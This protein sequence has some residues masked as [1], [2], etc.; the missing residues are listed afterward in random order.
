ML[1][2][3]PQVLPMTLSSMK[4]NGSSI[5]CECSRTQC[6]RTQSPSVTSH[7]G[8]SPFLDTK[9]SPR[10]GGEIWG[11]KTCSQP[12]ILPLNGPLI[13]GQILGVSEP[14]FS[15]HEFKN[16]DLSVL[17]PPQFSYL[18]Q[19]TS[20]KAHRQLHGLWAWFIAKQ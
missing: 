1:A 7:Q 15:Y 16:S 18:Q 8:H 19:K 5:V 17:D 12:P 13:L 9:K 20:D 4:V 11:Q 2:W 6:S 14:S 10:N 3:L